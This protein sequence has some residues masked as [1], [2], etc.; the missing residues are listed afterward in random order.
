MRSAI[1]KNGAAA[2]ERREAIDWLLCEAPIDADL[3]A[4]ATEAAA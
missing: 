2:K 3:R 1:L 4:Y